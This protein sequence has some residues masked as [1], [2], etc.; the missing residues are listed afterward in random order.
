MKTVWKVISNNW[1]LK[2]LAVILA[3]IFWMIVV[4]INDPQTTK[5][6]T[7]E[8]TV[9][10]E[11]VITDMGKVYEVLND[12][13][14]CVFTVTAPRSV[15]EQL[16]S[17]DFTVTADM[18]Q[19]EGL[20]LVPIEVTANRYANQISITKTTQNMQVS[21]ENAETKQFV[22][23]AG[24]TGTPADGY[25][26]GTVSV[27]PN[28]ITVTGAESIVSEISTV[29]ATISVEGMSENIKDKIS[30]VFYDEDGKEISSDSLTLSRDTVTVKAKIVD[31]T[32]VPIS[33]EPEGTPADGYEVTSV[34]C[35]PETIAVQGDDSVLS[36]LGE[37][38]LPSTLLDVTDAKKDKS[39]EVDITD[40][41]P[42]G[43]TLTDDADKTVTIAVTIEKVASK[44]YSVSTENLSVKNL[45][46]GLESA[47]KK[48]TVKITIMGNSE[49]L[50][51]LS[52]DEITGSVD[53]SDLGEGTYKLSISLS[54][55]E[56]KYTVDGLPTVSITITSES[57][58][59]QEDSS[60]T[61]AE[62]DTDTESESD[63]DETDSSE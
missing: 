7:A 9:E 36:E 21:V 55:D 12:S 17:S 27:S 56:D 29:K 10:N 48:D 47:F 6:F 61:D 2:L 4:N 51:D 22:I 8:V 30:P 5:Q 43:V 57:S 28:V 59:E 39:V 20:S 13:N 37:I 34:L 50:K 49:D 35:S 58:T 25:A 42:D 41:L 1:G 23:E 15:V 33:F 54:L 19:I 62:T 60:D 32:S 18:G 63:S 24:T 14:I 44:T 11:D 46:D 53:A 26:V 40:Y 3:I 45:G 52:A 38:V 16:N 31:Q